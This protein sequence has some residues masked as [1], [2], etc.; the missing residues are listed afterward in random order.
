MSCYLSLRHSSVVQI[1]K[2]SVRARDNVRGFNDV[3][4]N[5]KRSEF[6]DD[7]LDR[8]KVS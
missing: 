2:K 5:L 4:L 7:Y 1:D 3:L 6:Q 8:Y